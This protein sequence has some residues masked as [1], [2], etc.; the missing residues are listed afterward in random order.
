[1]RELTIRIRFTRA[2][3]GN[4]QE[5][6]GQGRFLLPRTPDRRVMFLS[7][8]HAQNMK[9][10]AS[11]LGRYQTE[12]DKIFWDVAID[13]N[14]GRDSWYKRYYANG[15]GRQ[16]YA[17]HEAFLPGTCVS[18]NCAVPTSISDDG[19]IQLMRLAG[20]YK[21]LSPHH[22]GEYGQFEVESVRS[23]RHSM[24]RDD[25]DH[26]QDSEGEFAENKKTS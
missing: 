8:W 17:L 21:G 18:I 12:I 9:L 16:R 6:H 7:T 13:G 24:L 5:K 19:M 15:S 11:L 22:P 3:L 1:M 26:T 20:R 25:D 2:C 23:R 4:V 14:P 10:A